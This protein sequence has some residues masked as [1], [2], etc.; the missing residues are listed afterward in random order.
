M[1]ETPVPHPLEVLDEIDQQHVRE[2]QAML[3]DR[4]TPWPELLTRYIDA[5]AILVA[6][7]SDQENTAE[8]QDFEDGNSDSR[9]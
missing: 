3:S 4:A 5:L 6:E 8:N 9:G 7:G 1:D 2:Q